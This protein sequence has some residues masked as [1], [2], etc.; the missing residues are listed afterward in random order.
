MLTMCFDGSGKS[1]DLHAPLVTLAGFA[2]DD[3]A[4][5]YFNAHWKRV[6][7]EHGISKLHMAE[8]MAGKPPYE[9]WSREQIDLLMQHL[10]LLP[11]YVAQYFKIQGA[12]FSIDASAH[13]KWAG[14]SNACS[15][16]ENLSLG[17]F[18]RLF[19]WYS[20]SPQAILEPIV[21]LYD[22]N[23]PYLNQMMQRWNRRSSSHKDKPWW[24][25]IASI[26]PVD[27]SQVYGVQAADMLAWSYNRIR[28]KGV[29]DFP[30]QIAK[31]VL[32]RVPHLFNEVEEVHFRKFKLI[33][34]IL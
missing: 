4:W 25:L 1:E 6:L 22:R 10:S 15:I 12:R 2:A 14:I 34:E 31:M 3:R 18:Y 20:N 21:I 11:S 33:G 29:D 7:D 17:A 32:D 27:G 26:A 9:G 19:Q 16:P 24:N 13:R 8:L 30:G 23:E 5:E 28:T